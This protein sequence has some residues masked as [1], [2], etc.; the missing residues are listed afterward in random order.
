[1]LSVPVAAGCRRAGYLYLLGRPLRLDRRRL[2]P[3]RH[4]V[5]QR[6][7]RRPRRRGRGRATTSRSRPGQV[8]FRLDDRTYRIA[9]RAR[10]GAARERAAADRRAARD[11]SPEA[12]RA[13]AGAGHA[14]LSAAR[15]RRASSSSSPSTSPRRRNSTRRATRSTPRASRSPRP[16]SRSPTRWPPWAAIPTS[17]PTEH[18]LVQQAQAQL[19]QA[20]ARSLAHRGRAP[21]DGIVTKVDKLPV[22]AISQRGDARPSRWSRPSTS[23]SRP[24]SRRPTS[25]TCGRARRRRSTSTPIPTTPSPRAVESIGAGTGSEFSVLPPQNATGNWVKVVQRIPVRLVIDD[26]DP[27]R[28]L[29][30]GMSVDVEVDTR[31]RQP[32]AGADRAASSAGPASRPPSAMPRLIAPAE[33]HAVRIAAWS[34]ISIMLATIMQAL[35]TTIANVALPHMQGSL[36]A[37]QDQIAWVLT[38]YIVAAAIATPLTGWLAG[39]FGRKRLFLVSIVGFTVASLLCGIGAEP[40]ADRALPP[41]AGRVRRGAGAAVAGDPAR[42]QSAREARPGDGDLGRRHHGRRRSSGRRWA[43][44]SPTTTTGAGCST[45]TCRSASSPSPASSA[46]VAETALDRDAAV[47]FLRLRH[48]EPR[49]RRACR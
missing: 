8:L 9:A 37:T 20:A 11:L 38:S 14:G 1:M 46:F 30:A 25:P 45:S 26:P 27:D 31:Y 2:R 13:E 40:G 18:P 23:G 47:R 22:G 32:A 17:P 39:R 24:I 19:D 28:P 4:G 3:G 43:A 21:L 42:H 12:R 35:D 41:A 29:R 16:S 10:Q 48:A 15:V 36:S 34:P 33:R 44:G 7:R 6:R 49:H 5:D